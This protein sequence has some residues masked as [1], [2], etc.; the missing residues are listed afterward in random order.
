[1]TPPTARKI[2]EALGVAVADLLERP[3]VPLGEAPQ[4]TGRSGEETLSLAELNRRTL[5]YID[6]IADQNRRAS[7]QSEASEV[8][9]QPY[10]VHGENEIV[11]LLSGER[12]DVAAQVVAEVGAR[13]RLEVAERDLKIARLEAELETTERDNALLRQEIANLTAEREGA[14]R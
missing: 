6:A 13:L 1:V 11:D 12:S 8:I 14:E 5:E 9:P 4:E 10:F 7:A 2:A 3:P